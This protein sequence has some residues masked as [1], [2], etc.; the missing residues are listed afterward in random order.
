[1]QLKWV[2]TCYHFAIKEKGI[3]M[4][5]R[6]IA[7]DLDGTLLNSSKEITDYTIEVLHKAVARKIHIVPST[8]RSRSGIPEAIAS[9]PFVHYALTLNGALVVN[10]KT[11]EIIYESVYTREEGLYLWNFIQKYDAIPDCA[12][13]GELYME[14]QAVQR[15]PNY[16]DS[17]E[18]IAIMKQTRKETENIR[19]MLLQDGA[20]SAKMNLLFSDMK[21]RMRARRELEKLSF[22]DVSSSLDKNLELNHKGGNKGNGLKALASHLNIKMNEVMALGDGDNDITMIKEAGLGIAMANAVPELKNIAD[23]LTDSNDD[24][25]VARAIER[26]A[27]K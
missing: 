24:D 9:L 5:I 18:R 27:L 26:W 20:M 1:M 11:E 21:E 2:I 16:V 12:V 19:E 13:D 15:L 22:V 25:G 7:L 17:P 14:Q 6:L 4:S 10:L 8:G 3:K 23:A